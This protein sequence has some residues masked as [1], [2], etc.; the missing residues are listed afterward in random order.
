[1]KLKH[2]VAAAAMVAAAAPALA[3]ISLPSTGNG[4]LFAVVLDRVDQVSYLVDLGLSMDAGVAGAT[5]FDGSTNFSLALNSANFAAF[6]AAAGTSS[7]PFEFA[8]MAGDG[9]GSTAASPKRLFSTINGDTT[10]LGNQLL[11]N[12][13]SNMGTFANYQALE[14]NGQTHT[15]VDNGDGWAAVG[16]NAYFLTQNMDTFNGVTTS[17][18]WANTNTEGTAAAFRKFAT[19]STSGG[20]QTVQST[21]AGVWTL[22]QATPGSYTLNYTVAAVPEADGLV[23]LA[24]GIAAMGFVGRRRQ[25]L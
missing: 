16:N 1:M 15:S 4:E 19:S 22:D 12:S 3:T 21:F 24:V 10:P 13:T 18:G 5:V 17:Q 20:A 23:L 6:Q 25:G 14:A 11:T 8:V 2:I 7:N 9:L